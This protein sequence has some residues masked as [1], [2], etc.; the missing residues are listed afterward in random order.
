[1]LGTLVMNSFSKAFINGALHWGGGG[2]GCSKEKGDQS[3]YYR[4][5]W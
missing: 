5:I 1:M 4:I 2:G 3:F